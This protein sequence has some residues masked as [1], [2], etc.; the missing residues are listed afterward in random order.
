MVRSFD[1][2]AVDEKW[3]DKVCENALWSPTAGNSAGVRMYTVSKEH[4]A[5][6]LMLPPIKNGVNH[7]SELKR[8]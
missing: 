5:S 8:S 4:V 7:Q 1:G 2:S 3:L 6:I